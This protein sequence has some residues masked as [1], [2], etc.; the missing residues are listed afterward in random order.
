MG[1]LDDSYALAKAYAN[2]NNQ[3]FIHPF[4]DKAVVEGQ[5]TVGLEILN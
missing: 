4:D 3:S 1:H 5:A 2:Q